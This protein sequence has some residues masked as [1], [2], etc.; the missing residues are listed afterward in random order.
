MWK[1]LPQQS[2]SAK[3]D[4]I[5]RFNSPQVRTIALQGLVIFVATALSG[6]R[7]VALGV[8]AWWLV[9][10]AL[11]LYTLL[12]SIDVSVEV[13]STEIAVWPWLGQLTHLT[14]QHRY[15]LWA[16]V[17]VQR[18]RYGSLRLVFIAGGRERRI[19]LWGLGFPPHNIPA[20][21]RAIRINRTPH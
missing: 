9:P 2:Q 8:A 13:T 6:L 7:V 10:L 15:P 18:L 19:M 16:L 12:L 3:D 20:L 21:L 4:S 14:W 17:D 1:P 5:L 11:V